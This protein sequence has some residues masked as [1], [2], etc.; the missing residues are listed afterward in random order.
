[1]KKT[2]FLILTAAAFL[3]GAGPLDA[4]E[5]HFEPNKPALAAG[6]TA[7]VALFVKFEHRRC[8]IPIE[9]TRIETKN[10]EIVGRGSWTEIKSGLFRLDLEIKAGTGR[11]EVRVT[12]EC[13]KKGL[14][15]GILVIG[16][17]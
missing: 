14:S 16:S 8:D 17:K 6:Q 11:G 7:A 5:I 13:D 3:A 12:R 1:M 10:V 9:D 15:E 2:V 4:C